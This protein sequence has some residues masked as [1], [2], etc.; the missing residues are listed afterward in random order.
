MKGRIKKTRLGHSVDYDNLAGINRLRLLE[1]EN[2]E[3][4]MEIN[5]MRT[6]LELNK[7]VIIDIVS[8]GD[9]DQK[10]KAIV[11]TI[12]KLVEEN[13]QLQR[14]TQRVQDEY[15]HAM[16]DTNMSMFTQLNPENSPEE[17]KQFQELDEE[18]KGRKMHHQRSPEIWGENSDSFNKAVLSPKVESDR[19]HIWRTCGCHVPKNSSSKKSLKEWKSPGI[20]KSVKSIVVRSEKS[21]DSESYSSVSD[22]SSEEEEEQI[23]LVTRKVQ[24]TYT[25]SFQDKIADFESKIKS[26]ESEIESMKRQNMGKDLII[27]KLEAQI[28]DLEKSLEEATQI[29][30]P[31]EEEIQIKTLSQECQVNIENDNDEN[32]ELDFKLSESKRI[33]NKYQDL[34]ENLQACYTLPDECLN[35]MEVLYEKYQDVFRKPTIPSKP[36]DLSDNGEGD[37][38]MQTLESYDEHIPVK[39]D[40][41]NMR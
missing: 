3:L 34:F 41:L 26:L 24:T 39:D 25:G 2:K 15:K 28:K 29:E 18:S 22:E 17:I 10:H 37:Q 5:D 21:N 19:N 35:E 11:N 12:N 38:Q 30:N 27:D 7:T 8:A 16:K 32:F 40:E 33:L 6:N 14:E 1:Q 36:N 13:L 23:I 4:N 9:Y 31:E 20:M